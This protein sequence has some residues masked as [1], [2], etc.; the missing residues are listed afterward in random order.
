M[1][2]GKAVDGVRGGIAKGGGF[3]VRVVGRHSGRL[4]GDAA[5]GRPETTWSDEW[6]KWEA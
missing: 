4:E 1:G 6:G 3:G 2:E 5:Q